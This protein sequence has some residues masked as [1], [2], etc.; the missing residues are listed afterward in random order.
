MDK[1]IDNSNLKKLNLELE[2]NRILLE[3]RIQKKFEIEFILGFA[4]E[5]AKD[6][7]YNPE[8]RKHLF[9]KYLKADEFFIFDVGGGYVFSDKGLVLHLGDNA[10][11][12]EFFRLQYS[13]FG[14]IK[15]YESEKKLFKTIPPGMQISNYFADGKPLHIAVPDNV[16]YIFKSIVTNLPKRLSDF[17]MKEN[18]TKDILMKTVSQL[19]QQI[20]DEK[21]KL[22]FSEL[23]KDN[24]GEVDLIEGND[25]NSLLQKNQKKVIEID[26][27]YIQ[28]FV[29]IS[30]YIKIKKQN[31]QNIYESIKISDNHSELDERI[32]LLKNQV[33]TYE[34]LLFHSI[35]MIAAIVKEDMIVF[36]EIYESF[37]KLG[38][39]N[40]N[41]ENDVAEKLVNIG[42][43][44]DDLMYSIYQMES[45]IVSEIG[46][47]SY[48]TQ[49]SFSELNNSVSRQLGEIDSTL[50]F[51]NLLSGIQTYQL[52]KINQSTKT[53]RN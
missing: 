35:N 15:F 42:D 48:V 11:G 31:I 50:K 52:Y 16:F 45:K 10:I 36:Y 27:D 34:L 40:S 14:R 6:K 9:E 44:L 29:K 28:K 19:E 1:S 53:L 21:R 37:D 3:E 17:C 24:N 22:L 41:W 25:F 32:N 33:H 18:Q 2:K 30:N 8:N 43:K 26:R 5:I 4:R 13:E 46:N 49:E 12:V 7:T 20:F 47:L 39:F 38:I 23:D 51:N